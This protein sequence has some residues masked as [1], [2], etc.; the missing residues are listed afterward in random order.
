[1]AAACF[2]RVAPPGWWAVSAGVDPGEALSATAARQL[3]GRAVPVMATRGQWLTREDGLR[4][5][6]TLHPSALLRVVD[7]DRDE[8]YGLWLADL[9]RATK[10]VGKPPR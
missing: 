2:N 6:I 3:M 9:R 7:D 5:L 4:V 10:L 1:M 8:A